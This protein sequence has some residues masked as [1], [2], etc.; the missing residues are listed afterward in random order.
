MDT[1]MK[2]RINTK[3]I[4]S[5]SSACLLSI[6]SLYAGMSA[7]EDTEIY[8]ASPTTEDDSVANVMFMFDT[9]G[10]MSNWDNAGRKRI[11]RLKEAMVTVLTEATNV[12]IG[13]GSFNGRRT[14]GSIRIPATNVDQDLCPNAE[15]EEI[16]VRT[17]IGANAD[18]AEEN[19]DGSIELYGTYLEMKNDVP[20]EDKVKTRYT[21]MHVNDDA[22][23]TADT[24]GGYNYSRDDDFLPINY[25]P[26]IE[27]R[28]SSG[29]RFPDVKIPVGATI[30]EANLTFK[31]LEEHTRGYAAVNITL[32][33][34][35]ES[36]R[37]SWNAGERVYDRPYLDTRVPWS[38]IRSAHQVSELDSPQIHDLITELIR[39]P[40]W[41]GMGNLTFKLEF[42]GFA[43]GKNDRRGFGSHDSGDLPVLNIVYTEKELTPRYAGLRFA[44]LNIPRGA[45]ITHAT[46]DVQNSWRRTA[47]SRFTIQGEAV[48]DSA[49]FTTA[50]A[51]LSSRINPSTGNP[52]SA[53]SEWIPNEWWDTDIKER[54]SEV[55]DIVQEI[56]NRDGWCGGNAMSL[57]IFGEGERIVDTR[58]KDKYLAAA[59]Q[60]AYDPRT[61]DFSDTCL[62]KVETAGIANGI[63]DV[64]E[65]AGDGDIVAREGILATHDSSHEEQSIGLRF[66]D[67]K[68]PQGAKITDAYI[69]L[70]SAGGKDG[71][72]AL[73]VSVEDTGYSEVFDTTEE[74]YLTDSIEGESLWWWNVKLANEGNVI[75]SANITKLVDSVISRGDW[76]EGNPMSFRLTPWEDL[77]G[78]RFFHSA[79]MVGGT[80]PRLVI[81][82]QVDS[83]DLDNKPTTLV[84][85][86]DEVIRQMLDMGT[87]GGTPLMDAYYESAL[88]MTGRKVEYGLSRHNTEFVDARYHRTS[89]AASYTGATDRY[90]PPNCT[91]VDLDNIACKEVKVTGSPTYIQPEFGECRANQIVLLSDGHPTYNHIETDIKKMIGADKVCADRPDDPAEP[92]IDGS[93]GNCGVELANWLYQT[94][95]DPVTSGKQGIV[96]HTVGL[97]F[98]N[99]LLQDIARAGHGG[100]YRADT[101]SELTRAFKSIIQHALTLDSSF[102]APSSATSLT[103]R[104]VNS[105]EVYFAMF[106]PGTNAKWDGNLKKYQLGKNETT[107]IVEILDALANP[108]ID[109]ANGGF[110]DTAQSLWS[111]TTDG[112]QV[113]KG[114]AAS[115]LP[116]S[117]DLYVSLSNAAG[118]SELYEFH[119]SNT[120][121]TKQLLG[122]TSSDDAYRTELLRWARGVDV[123]DA[124]NDG[125]VNEVRAQM[126]DPLHSTQAILSYGDTA[127]NASSII[128]VGTNEGFLHAIDTDTGVEEFAFIPE[129]LLINLNQF[130]KNDAVSHDLRPHGLDGEVS[131]WHADTNNNGLVDDNEKAYVYVGMRRGGRNYYAIDVSDPDNPELQWVIRGGTAPFRNLAE[132]WSRPVKARVNYK[133]VPKDVL[134]FAAGYDDINDNKKELR[135]DSDGRGFFIV[136]ATTGKLI[137][138]RD[139]TDFD[140]MKYSIPADLRVINI[141]N[142]DFSD[143]IFVG[144]MGGQIWR[145][146]IDNSAT[147]DSGFISGAV[148]ASFAD[149]DEDEHRRFFSEIDLAML[150]DHTGAV[151]LN[152]AAGSGAR[153]N[154][155]RTVVDDKFYSFRSIDVFGPPRDSDGDIEYPDPITESDLL[156]VTTTSGSKDTSGKIAKGWYISLESA[157]EKSLSGAITLDNTI[158][159]TTYVPADNHESACRATVGEGRVYSVSAFTGDA[160]NP[161]A[162]G[163]LDVI[164]NRYTTLKTPGIPSRVSG[165]IVEAS[166]NTVSTFAGVE[167]LGSS[168]E[169]TP[170]ERTFWA[171][172]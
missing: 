46:I 9:S 49:P 159:F 73:N 132:T 6:F 27:K 108:A 48:D 91:E 115:K 66:S 116:S 109:Q 106:K 131:A 107:N 84:S 45:T 4:V 149:D 158:I 112:N 114:G 37:F 69:T 153:P 55:T 82:Y 111:G 165:L 57:F 133:N 155:N 92:D 52:T 62:R 166:P 63:D 142:D 168:G 51:A 23:E 56:V 140:D 36:P 123:N 95:H 53:K 103:N 8:F 1:A 147:T 31:N 102:V 125:N 42:R 54:T 67:I 77:E 143:M 86:R 81:H 79:D 26:D 141:D 124:D 127:E 104:L 90:L 30:L 2:S 28:V 139:H 113:S 152:I 94:D 17:A 75:R 47:P 98:T 157:G 100:Y 151:F 128:Y 7:A 150:R 145:F 162:S 72:V 10:S 117:R 35:T 19:P 122:I 14:G 43:G 163:G 89:A 61:I 119:E 167:S 161:D 11:S 32:D 21:T 78:R 93:K 70:A 74:E 44:D 130:Y 85:G 64:V 120:R 171:E 12:N 76:N 87:N 164:S 58:E 97:N 13:I 5:L 172:Q 148:I 160:V 22:R 68:V 134:I 18:D 29:V 146:D 80:S 34:R 169:D 105:N 135:S 65:T 39:Q 137:S 24:G 144:D 118:D 71:K 170:F 33:K 3:W 88:Y 38:N 25:D 50:N 59:L 83:D 40:T 41:D 101:A 99:P 96:T 136:D 129:E 60:V 15:C 121:V 156:D 110:K 20:E 16:R 154:P 126:G 138:S